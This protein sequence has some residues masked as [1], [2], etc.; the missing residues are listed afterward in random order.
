MFYQILISTMAIFDPSRPFVVLVFST[1]RPAIAVF[2]V[3]YFNSSA[4]A[5]VHGWEK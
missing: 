5:Q 2:L 3:R 4:N 1:H